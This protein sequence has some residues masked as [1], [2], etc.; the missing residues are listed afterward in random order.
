[1]CY[2]ISNIYKKLCF[3]FTRTHTSIK[4]IIKKKFNNSEESNLKYALKDNGE[5]LD[6]RLNSIRV[7]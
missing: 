2:V 3:F 4:T 1:M 7:Y 5:I 6:F